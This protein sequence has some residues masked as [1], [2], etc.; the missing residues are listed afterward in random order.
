MTTPDEQPNIPPS[1]ELHLLDPAAVRFR[2]VGHRMEV[3]LPANP[4]EG[5]S[6]LEP[7]PLEGETPVEAQ[8][9]EATLARLFP[10]SEPNAWIAVLNTEGTE[11]GVLRDLHGLAH[12]SLP[13]LREELRRRY[14]VP[15]ITAVTAIRDR[16]DVTEWRVET[17]RGAASFQVRG[18]SDNLKQPRPG[19]IAITDVEGNRYDIPD[20]NALDDDSRQRLQERM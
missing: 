7:R 14:L 5:E 17:D 19:Y 8:W 18:L 10:L 12:D 11:L 3:L 13:A 2:T 1:D 4:L 20:V 9:T 6:P 15:H 16:A